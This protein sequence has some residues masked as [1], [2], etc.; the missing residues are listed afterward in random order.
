HLLFLLSYADSDNLGSRVKAVELFDINTQRINYKKIADGSFISEKPF[1]SFS[2]RINAAIPANVLSTAHISWIAEQKGILRL[3]DLLPLFETKYRTNVSVKLPDYWKISTAESVTHLNNY[4]IGNAEN[5]AFII[6]KGWHS[7]AFKVSDAIVNLVLDAQWKIDNEI[8]EQV[9]KDIL[10]KYE[11]YFGAIPEK[12]LNI[13]NFRFP[14]D[15]GFERWRA[16]TFG[17]N[18]LVM[19]APPTFES[20]I[21]QRFQEQLRHELFHLWMPNN[22]AFSGDYSWFYE[23]FAQYTALKSGVELNQIS[24]NDFLNTIEQSYNLG[25]RRSQP[26]SLIEASKNRRFDENSSVYAKGLAVAFLIDAALLRESKGKRGLISV[27]RHIYEKHKKPN[28]TEDGN[29]AILRFFD[30]FKEL[31][32]VIND[33]VR[34]AEKLNFERYLQQTGIEILPV[35]TNIK[36][37]IKD[38]LTGREKDFL[39][40]LGYNNWR[41]ILSK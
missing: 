6:G 33:Y 16:E 23:G 37:K 15:V 31:S 30:G 34:G 19:S 10:L 13:V 35:G 5:T 29:A 39:D 11:S 17:G 41:K 38:R 28:I 40:N 4:F 22:L 7:R 2:Y 21:R 27:L 12:N 8:V 25:N 20:Q 1:N 14:K 32:P 18:I 36:L 3:N 9:T 26:I 24:F